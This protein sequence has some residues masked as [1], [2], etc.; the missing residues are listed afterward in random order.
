MNYLTQNNCQYLQNIV[1]FS[2]NIAL[3]HQCHRDWYSLIC[4]KCSIVS[5]CVWYKL[6]CISLYKKRRRV[7]D[8]KGTKFESFS[9]KSQVS[10]INGQ[11]IVPSLKYCNLKIS[12]QLFM[13][14][15]QKLCKFLW[16]L[17]CCEKGRKIVPILQESKTVE[18][19]R[20]NVMNNSIDP[21][22]SKW[23]VILP[24][25]ALKLSQA[26][27]YTGSN[28]L[29][30]NCKIISVASNKKYKIADDSAECEMIVENPKVRMFW[31]YYLSN[32]WLYSRNR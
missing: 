32:F 14:M 9:R 26:L 13:I 15:A 4:T 24:T 20:K 28:L 2:T 12:N 19:K 6:T 8:D 11:K 18:W 23:K 21:K 27:E 31:N 22:W 10:C 7:I 1:P 3:I 16:N 5:I 25:M 30:V 29:I 17:E